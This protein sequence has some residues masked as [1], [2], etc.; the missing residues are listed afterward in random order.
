MHCAAPGFFVT[1][2]YEVGR[3]LK[4]LRNKSHDTELERD[5]VLANVSDLFLRVARH[6]PTSEN[7]RDKE[8]RCCKMHCVFSSRVTLCCLSSCISNSF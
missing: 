1:R 8:Y 4:A 3:C 7:V 5:T 6:C 2:I